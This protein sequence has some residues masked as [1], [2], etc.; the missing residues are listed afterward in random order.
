MTNTSLSVHEKSGVSNISLSPSSQPKESHFGV[1]DG[2]LVVG[3]LG[4]FIGLVFLLAK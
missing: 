2:A 1:I 4:A 3:F